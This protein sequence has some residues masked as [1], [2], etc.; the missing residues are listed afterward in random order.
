MERFNMISG[1]VFEPDGDLRRS[2]GIVTLTRSDIQLEFVVGSRC[3]VVTHATVSHFKAIKG[4][5]HIVA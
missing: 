3:V 1:L 5:S 4:G 2:I